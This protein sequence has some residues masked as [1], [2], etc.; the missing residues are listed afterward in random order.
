MRFAG[1]IL[2]FTFAAAPIG[3]TQRRSVPF[4]GSPTDYRGFSRYDFKVD[5]CDALVVTP[6]TPAKGRPWIWRAEFF[7]VAEETDLALLRRG[8]HLV[9]IQVGNTFGCPSA[10]AHWNVFYNLLTTKYGLSKR[11]ALE[12]LSRG[13]LYIYNWAAAHPRSV[14]CIYGDAPVC[15]FK[16]WPGG[17]G[18]SKGSPDDWNALI[19]DYGFAD[20]RAALAYAGNPID[21]LKPLARA[22]IPIIHVVGDADDV[23]PVN[24]NTAIVQDRYKKL[25]GT[26]EL[27]V[28][29]GVGHH[30][31]GLDDPTPIVDFILAHER[32]R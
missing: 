20:E 29:H 2:L 26:F 10:M 11:P 14:G 16:S 27:I 7:G 6:T 32:A 31:H 22:H 17:K 25:G 24:E 8:W 3:A 21:N 12:G 1:L 15:D 5:G 4:P 9:Y 23:V 28:K 18:Q 19:H 30:P 13:G